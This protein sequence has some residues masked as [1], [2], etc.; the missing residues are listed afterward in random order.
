MLKLFFGADPATIAPEQV[1]AHRAKLTEW[2]NFREIVRGV[3]FPEGPRRALEAG[4]GH[5]REWVK[6]WGSLL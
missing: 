1:V 5:E 4:I 3:D 6:F 2:E